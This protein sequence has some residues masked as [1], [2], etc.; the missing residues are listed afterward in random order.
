MRS[1]ATILASAAAV[2]LSAGTAMADGM[3]IKDGPAPVA[4]ARTCDGG[5]FAGFYIGAA[6]GYADQDTNYDFGAPGSASSDDGGFTG[7]LYSGYNIQCGRFVVGYES[8]WNFMDADSTWVD[9]D[10]SCGGVP[11]N[12][13]SSDIRFYGTSRLRFGLVHSDNMMFYATGGLAYASVD[14]SLITPALGFSSSAT[15]WSWGWTAGGGIEFLRDGRWG[16][17][18]E[19]LYIDLSETGKGYIGDPGVCGGFCVA[20]VDYDNDFWVGRI[21]LTYKFGP[22]EEAIVPMK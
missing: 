2:L 22:R 20:N 8:D 21:G 7:G 15:D 17:R 16:L 4:E 11:C 19:A 12:T 18:A 1:F 6:V 3:S 9:P 14:N 5:P 10:T 13:T